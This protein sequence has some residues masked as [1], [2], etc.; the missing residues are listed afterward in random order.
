MAVKLVS[1]RHHTCDNFTIV[2]NAISRN[3]A[4]A[5][6]AV[7][8]K[9]LVVLLGRP[10]ISELSRDTLADNFFTEGRGQI[11]RALNDLETAGFLR[12][13]RDETGATWTVTSE[14]GKFD[15]KSSYPHADH[16]S[17]LPCGRKPTSGLEPEPSPRQVCGQVSTTDTYSLIKKKTPPPSPPV[18]HVDQAADTTSEGG[19]NHPRTLSLLASLTRDSVPPSRS[20][21]VELVAEINRLLGA[22]ADHGALRKALEADMASA[23][24]YTSVRLARLRAFKSED[25]PGPSRSRPKQPSLKMTDF[26]HMAL[27]RQSALTQIDRM[28]KDG[29]IAPKPLFA[30]AGL[31]RPDR[32]RRSSE[33]HQLEQKVPAS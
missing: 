4:V 26:P 5:L 19:R 24:N 28:A 21:H 33:C 20:K 17:D 8:F 9:L 11:R 31:E 7:A 3:E 22:G 25:F 12:R 10:P 6:D 27:N 30:A 32:P 16:G 2:A 15:D 29:Y 18:S 13:D 23:R 14:P 1:L